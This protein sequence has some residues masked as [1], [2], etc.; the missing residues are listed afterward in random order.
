MRA[1]A[2]SFTAFLLSYLTSPTPLL[3]CL[4]PTLLSFSR[5]PTPLLSYFVPALLSYLVPALLYYL[6]SALSSYFVPASSFLIRTLAAGSL[7]S[8]LVSCPETSTTSL[9]CPVLIPAPTH[10]VSLAFKTFKQALLD[11]FL[12]RCL[13]SSI[14]VFCSF[15]IFGLLPKKN[16]YKRPFNTAFINSR[17][18]ASNDTA[19]KVDL[20]YTLCGCLI[21]VNFNQLWQLELLDHKLVYIIE[22]IFLVAI[23]FWDSL[24]ASYQRYTIK[25]ALKL[26]LRMRSITSKIIKE[27]ITSV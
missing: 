23:L 20:S 12:R 5:S 26:G 10:L 18:F 7:L 27:K 3:S 14:E 1:S 16:K 2:T 9:F 19:K 11:E 17:P 4:M 15:S 21:P 24:F 22:A 6:M 25:L 8:I 13:T